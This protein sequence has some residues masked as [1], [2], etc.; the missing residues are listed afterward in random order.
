MRKVLSFVLVLAL[1]LSSFSMAFAATPAEKT[2]GAPNDVVGETCEEAVTAL[3]ALNVVAGYPDGTYKPA[4][5]VT[6]AEMAKLI[7]T[8]LGLEEFAKASTTSFKDMA[9]YDWAKGYVGYAVSLGVIKGYPDGTFKPGNTVSYDEAITMIVRALGYT[10]ACKE[11]NGTW[12]AVFTQKAR[13]LGILDDVKA[14]GNAGANRGDVAIL[15]YNALPATVGYADADG[16][17]IP[18]LEKDG[19]TNVA[20]I[21]N[22]DAQEVSYSIIEGTED[23][24]VNIKPYTGAYAKTYKLTKGTYEDYIVAVGDCKSDFVTGE[25]KGNDKV[26]K[27]VD[28]TE[29]KLDTVMTNVIGNTK[30]EQTL[31]FVNGGK[32]KTITKTDAKAVADAGLVEG[33]VVTLAADITGKTVNGIYSVLNW[34]V[35]AEAVVDADDVKDIAENQTLLGKEFELDDNDEID[36]TSFDLVGVKSLEDIKA[37]NVVYVYTNGDDISR[38]AVGTKTVEGEIT[39]ITSQGQAGEKVTID[40]T[41]Y[42]YASSKITGV[43]GEVNPDELDTEDVVKLYL[44][45]YGYIYDYDAVSGKADNFAVVLKTGTKGGTLSDNANQIKLFTKDAEAVTFDVDDDL[46]KAEDKV[47]GVTDVNAWNAYVTSGAI[48]KYGLDKAG[49][50]DSFEKIGTAEDLI[51]GGDNDKDISPK[52]YYA[53]HEIDKNAVIFS[54]DFNKGVNDATDDDN[55]AVTTL[56]KVLDTED[57]DADFLYDDKNKIVAMIIYDYSDNDDTYGV[58]TDR[59][60]NSSDAGY[61]VEFFVNG[62]AVTYNSNK[63]GYD[64]AK[65]STANA[66]S[67]LGFKLYKI[68]FDASGDVKGLDDALTTAY[69]RAIVTIGASGD[70]TSYSSRVFTTSVAS[71]SV[72]GNVTQ[73]VKKVTL[74]SDTHVYY[75]DGD[76]FKVGGLSDL[77]NVDGKT[78]HFF[79]T[80]D[81]DGVYDIVIISK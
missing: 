50:I 39:K 64:N 71:I 23:S 16:K 32:S 70:T 12:P 25:Y 5:T 44:D 33:Q 8:E 9:G 36:L 51:S 27:T 20:L 43:V 18:K 78:I 55:Y 65:E 24:L 35:V 68:N 10:E 75:V 62:K 60:K 17:W 72:T 6:R 46:F 45:A 67:N 2:A 74:D 77:R 61:Q 29:Y 57:V 59:A 7:V 49:T 79:D 52:G 34:D 11:M 58:V 37:D 42:Q 76:E 14:G 26:I 15:L 81:D 63:T 22:L 31:V 47:T 19:V 69:Q 3:T 40:G 28:G 73:S 66:A 4:Q 38:V 41:A 21:T 80:V 53:G 48:V 54:Y 1:V 13:V 56:D 30:N